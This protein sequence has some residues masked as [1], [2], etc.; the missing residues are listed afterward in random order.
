MAGYKIIHFDGRV[1]KDGAEVKQ[2]V[3]GRQYLRFSVANNTYI[4]GQE[5]TEWFDVKV[6][7][8]F[9]IENVGKLLTKG[10][11][12]S[13]VGVPQTETN[14]DKN[15][16]V[17]VNQYVTASIVSVPSVGKSG[18]KDDVVNMSSGLTVTTD[19]AQS[20]V[21]VPEP[22]VYQPTPQVTPQVAQPVAP[23]V[24]QQ[25]GQNVIPSEDVMTTGSFDDEIPF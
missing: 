13:I 7:D 25:L 4:N 10:K 11:Y 22:Q 14:V 20:Q 17:W 9:L 8:P 23:Q 12:V 5:K 3:T 16:R 6:F 19:V 15:G 1:G 2:T 24:A 18:D 21:A